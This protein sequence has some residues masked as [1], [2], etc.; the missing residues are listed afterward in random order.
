MAQSIQLESEKMLA[1]NTS[2]F[3]PVKK[4]NMN[5]LMHTSSQF[6]SKN[7]NASTIDGGTVHSSLIQHSVSVKTDADPFEQAHNSMNLALG[8]PTQQ[9]GTQS[10]QFSKFGFG[11]ANQISSFDSKRKSK[12]H[13]TYQNDSIMSAT[14]VLTK[15]ETT[16]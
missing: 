13:S 5:S 3:G 6:D 9:F 4:M 2:L 1:R 14:E 15:N 8:K 11:I 10:K 7:M 16:I 12:H